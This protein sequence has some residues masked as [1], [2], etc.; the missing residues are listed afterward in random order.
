[1]DNVDLQY[2]N[3]KSKMSIIIFMKNFNLLQKDNVFSKSKHV[4]SEQLQ[5]WDIL[6]SKIGANI[7]KNIAVN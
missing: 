1:M 3:K 2:K 4:H 6:I 7:R 5:N